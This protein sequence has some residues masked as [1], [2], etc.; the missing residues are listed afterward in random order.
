[1]PD[2]FRHPPTFICLREMTAAGS[3]TGAVLSANSSATL[4]FMAALVF[5][6]GLLLGPC[7]K[8]AGMAARQGLRHRFSG[9][10]IAPWTPKAG[11]FSR[12]PQRCA[13]VL[14]AVS[15]PPSAKPAFARPC[16][17]AQAWALILGCGWASD[18]RPALGSCRDDRSLLGKRGG[19]SNTGSKGLGKFFHSFAGLGQQGLRL[20]DQTSPAP[21][22][23]ALGA[24]KCGIGSATM[25]RGRGLP[26]SFAASACQP[27]NHG[28]PRTGGDDPTGGPATKQVPEGSAGKPFRSLSTASAWGGCFK[29]T[30][31]LLGRQGFYGEAAGCSAFK[32]I[33]FSINQKNLFPIPLVLKGLLVSYLIY[34]EWSLGQFQKN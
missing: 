15:I 21:A 29:E 24:W 13:E 9:M 25:A 12:Q 10:P 23:L 7:R 18:P 26:R 34:A 19:V 16:L 32:E 1:L 2:W 4:K 28:E 17:Q 8:G 31:A 20:R 33:L 6:S 11:D 22:D 27:E 30:C 3:G 5:I 14:R